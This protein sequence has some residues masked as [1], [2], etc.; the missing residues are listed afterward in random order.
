MGFKAFNIFMVLLFLLSA[1]VQLNDPDPLVW[2]A[3]YLSAAV[4]SVAHA[5]RKLP[6]SW[7]MAFALIA[8]LW[9]LTLVPAFFGQVSLV[10]VFRLVEMKTEEVEVAREFGGLMIVSVWM[11]VLS[12]LA[13]KSVHGYQGE[14]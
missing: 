5:I 6:S 1:A 11:G 9:A 3:L 12:L 13:K 8:F 7:P 2:I 14:R 10:D 4:F